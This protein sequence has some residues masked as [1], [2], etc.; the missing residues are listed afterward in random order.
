MEYDDKITNF[1]CD[2]AKCSSFWKYVKNKFKSH[3][4]NYYDSIMDMDGKYIDSNMLACTLNQKFFNN[5]LTKL[6]TNCIY[7]NSDQFASNITTGLHW[8]ATSFAPFEH[9]EVLLMI[10]KLKYGKSCGVDKIPGAI[11]YFCS[12]ILIDHLVKL[13][14]LILLSSEIPKALKIAKIIPILKKSFP[15]TIEDFRPISILPSI[16]KIFESLIYQHLMVKINLDNILMNFQFG[17]W[18]KVSTVNNLII[19]SNFIQK[20]FDNNCGVDAIYFDFHKAFDRVNHNQ[21]LTKM[22]NYGFDKSYL[23][24]ISNYLSGRFQ[25]TY[26]NKQYSD[27]LPCPSGVLQ[28]SI[29]SPV[30]FNLFIND[31]TSDLENKCILYADDIKLYACIPNDTNTYLM[32]QKSLQNDIDHIFEWSCR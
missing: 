31:L 18:K 26:C 4:S 14:N 29:I 25:V 23:T 1:V 5:F 13:F 9:D 28:G 8:N 6:V 21:L 16:S 15:T 12:D 30:L 32:H 11:F 20:C 19:A 17:F 10:S 7:N 2:N 22:F 27:Y 3:P 24:V